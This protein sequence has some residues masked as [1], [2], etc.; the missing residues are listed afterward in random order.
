MEPFNFFNI[1]WWNTNK[2]NILHIADEIIYLLFLISVLYLLFFALMALSS[3]KI[4]YEEAKKKHKFI[5]IF[6]VSPEE[7]HNI[8]EAIKDLQNQDYPTDKYD[9]IIGYEKLSEL[10]IL[11]FQ[12]MGIKMIP[13]TDSSDS[14]NSLKEILY[15]LPKKGYDMAL[16]LEANN[17]IVNNCLTK[18][19]DAY[20]S[21]CMAIQTHRVPMQTPSM[22]GRISRYSEEI[23]NSIFRKGHVQLGFSSA[24]NSSGVAI[25]YDWLKENFQE[26]KRD[27]IVK[28]LETSLLKQNIYIDYMTN[29]YT[30]LTRSTASSSKKFQKLHQKWQKEKYKNILREL[31]RFPIFFFQGNWDYCNKIIQWIIPSRIILTML[32]AF[33]TVITSIYD[34]TLSIKWFILFILLLITFIIAAPD[35]LIDKNNYTKHLK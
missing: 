1:F 27:D 14:G 2:D 8:T 18:L 3:W 33:F 24:L 12:Q 25:D 28:Q 6:T 15:E 11:Q 23:N 10:T 16:L 26:F 9:I 21:G 32:I 30:F 35:K 22:L 5:I 13:L 19:N 4:K 7:D 29:I 34:W 20:Y 31:P 17:T